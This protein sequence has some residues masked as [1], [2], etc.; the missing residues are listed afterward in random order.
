LRKEEGSRRPLWEDYLLS[1]TMRIT[2]G[3][4]PEHFLHSRNW[5]ISEEEGDRER[6]W[7]GWWWEGEEEASTTTTT[8]RS[9][10]PWRF[11]SC[12]SSL[13]EWEG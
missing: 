6:R 12:F 2:E 3:R 5:R 10:D 7:R 8:R 11:G 4:R 13:E 9:S 1:K